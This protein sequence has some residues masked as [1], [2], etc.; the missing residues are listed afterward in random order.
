[1]VVWQE[2][3]IGL[4]GGRR[5]FDGACFCVIFANDTPIFFPST[6]VYMSLSY[7]LRCSDYAIVWR[8]N[9]TGNQY[10]HERDRKQTNI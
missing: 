6:F 5:A 8:S 4:L 7:D 9:T 10:I 1:M 3:D 2:K